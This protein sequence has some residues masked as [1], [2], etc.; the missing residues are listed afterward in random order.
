M[1]TKYP[2]PART[3]ALRRAGHFVNGCVNGAL[4]QCCAKRIAGTVAICCA[5]MMLIDVIC[6]QERQLSSGK[7]IKQTYLLVYYS[8]TNLLSEESIIQANLNR[9]FYS[10]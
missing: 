8:E 4:L 7:S 6:T 3:H 5:D 1:R 9:W 2:S 10:C